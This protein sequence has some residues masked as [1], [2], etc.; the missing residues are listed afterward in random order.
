MF[1]LLLIILD[2]IISLKVVDDGSNDGPSE[3]Q[4]LVY[5]SCFP[6]NII[7]RFK[8]FE[9]V[10]SPSLIIFCF[11]FIL[12]CK[13]SNEFCKFKVLE[14]DKSSS[15]IKSCFSFIAVATFPIVS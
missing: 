9:I 11:K 3:E 14:I 12:F 13:T 6:A 8:I 15:F 2:D 1:L 10:K 4:L 5:T 7:P